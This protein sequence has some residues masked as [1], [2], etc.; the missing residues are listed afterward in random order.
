M[1]HIISNTYGT[2]EVGSG[3]SMNGLASYLRANYNYDSKYYIGGSVRRDGLSRLPKESRWSTFWIYRVHTVYLED[4]WQ[5]SS[6]NETLN[7]L[8]F[9]A[10]YAT[11]GNQDIGSSFLISTPV[12]KNMV[13][14]V[15]LHG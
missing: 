1:D 8:R 13:A 6:I 10:S 2:Q 9:R 14:K 3:K 15:V 11:V 12:H 5:N 4:F 7:D